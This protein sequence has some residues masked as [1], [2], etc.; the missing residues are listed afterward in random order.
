M[1]RLIM[2]QNLMSGRSRDQF[3]ELAPSDELPDDLAEHQR[4]FAI[5]GPAR[6]SVVPAAS[7]Q[8]ELVG[9]ADVTG[10]GR[11]LKPA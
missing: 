3:E 5:R 6:T 8:L 2:F 10:R 9:L 1:W 4:W 7:G 11:L